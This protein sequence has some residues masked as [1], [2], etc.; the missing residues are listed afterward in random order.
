M[1]NFIFQNTTKII[2][3][4]GTENEVGNEIKQCGKKVLLTHTGEAFYKESG[5]YDRV[6]NSLLLI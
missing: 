3:G 1:E 2:F 4:K 5:L 6:V